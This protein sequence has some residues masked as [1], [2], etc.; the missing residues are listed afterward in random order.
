MK[1]IRLDLSK[2]AV[3]SFTASS[4]LAGQGTV[5]GHATFGGYSCDA[6]ENTCGPQTCGDFYCAIDTENPDCS[7]TTTGTLRADSCDECLT[8]WTNSP[9]ECPCG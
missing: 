8:V 2:L 5:K 4:F 7:G 9:R 6:Q 3:E 1:K